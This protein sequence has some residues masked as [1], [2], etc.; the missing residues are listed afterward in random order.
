[1]KSSPSSGGSLLKKKSLTA[2]ATAFT[3][4][5]NSSMLMSEFSSNFWKSSSTWARFPGTRY[6]PS[7]SRPS[8]SMNSMA[9]CRNTGIGLSSEVLK[10][11]NVGTWTELAFP[12]NPLA[13]FFSFFSLSFSCFFCSFWSFLSDAS[14]LFISSFCLFLTSLVSSRCCFPRSAGLTPLF[15][16]G[17]TKE[18]VRTY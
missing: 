16:R 9:F 11:S 12:F 6:N 14:C 13:S 3:A 17:A 10:S 8:F 4:M 1:M 15:S 18:E 5:S 7:A 2:V